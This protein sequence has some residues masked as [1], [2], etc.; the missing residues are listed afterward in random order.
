MENEAV[1]VAAEAATVAAVVVVAGPVGE[2]AEMEQASD[3][4][5]PQQ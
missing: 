1:T 5:W 3:R 4:E 2:E